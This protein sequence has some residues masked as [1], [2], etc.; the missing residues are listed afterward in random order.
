MNFGAPSQGLLQR[1]ASNS[2]G[3]TWSSGQLRRNRLKHSV[4]SVALS[5]WLGLTRVPKGSQLKKGLRTARMS[6]P[7]SS[8]S[9]SSSP[10]GYSC[11]PTTLTS[12]SFSSRKTAFSRSAKTPTNQRTWE[13][14]TEQL[15]Q[16][17]RYKRLSTVHRLPTSSAPFLKTDDA[18]TRSEFRWNTNTGD[19]AP[20]GCGEGPCKLPVVYVKVLLIH[21]CRAFVEM[22]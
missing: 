13:R 7:S 6:D 4:C 11:E 17:T 12:P 2:R 10:A 20:R 18:R 22:Q 16:L 21:D 15:V 1:P 14:G 8:S 3:A 19:G 5:R 9:S